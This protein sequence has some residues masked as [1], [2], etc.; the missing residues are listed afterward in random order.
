MLE[1]ILDLSVV[2]P[3][4]EVPRVMTY[5]RIQDLRFIAYYINLPSVVFWLGG[6]L[7]FVGMGCF[8]RL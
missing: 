5:N 7:R 4:A 6:G 8:L 1:N 2:I 3:A